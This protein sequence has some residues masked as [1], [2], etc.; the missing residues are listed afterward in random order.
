MSLNQD[1]FKSGCFFIHRPIIFPQLTCTSQNCGNIQKR[2]IYRGLKI[3][4]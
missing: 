1:E 2:N 4:D 3:A